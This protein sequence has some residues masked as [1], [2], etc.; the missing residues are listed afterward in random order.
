MTGQVLAR[1]ARLLGAVALA[2]CAMLS[3]DRASIRTDIERANRAFEQAVAA[4][5]VERVGSLYTSD[6]IAFPPDAP[7]VRGRDAIKQLWG[8]VIRDMGLK[9]VTLRTVDVERAGHTAYETG[10]AT[11]RLE[12]RGGQASSAAIKYVVVWKRADGQ[13]RIHRDIWNAMPAR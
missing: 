11:L 12:P 8:G 6:A 1:S 2:G 13:W 7:M 9:T 3:P 10:E 5:D 4:G